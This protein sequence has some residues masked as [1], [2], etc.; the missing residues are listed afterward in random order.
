MA[1][2]NSP[3]E[4]QAPQVKVLVSFGRVEV[5]KRWAWLSGTKRVC[6]CVFDRLKPFGMTIRLSSA[7][8]AQAIETVL[9]ASTS[10]DTSHTW[11]GDTLS[12]VVRKN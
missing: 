5:L 12:N 11:E 9:V 6:V 10:L 2:R 3:L 8:V 1:I 4:A 7:S